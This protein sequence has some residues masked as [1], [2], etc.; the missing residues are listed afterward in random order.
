MIYDI[1]FNYSK[2]NL[3]CKLQSFELKNSE[4]G[5]QGYLVSHWPHALENLVLYAWNNHQ[6]KRI[7]M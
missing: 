1:V 2:T 4:A 3:N 7:Y 5:I 6:N